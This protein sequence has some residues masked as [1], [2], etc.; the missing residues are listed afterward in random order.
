MRD[1]PL[2]IIWSAHR[3]GRSSE[4]KGGSKRSGCAIWGGEQEQIPEFTPG[5][6][7]QEDTV[8]SRVSIL[9]FCPH[10][11]QSLFPQPQFSLFLLPLAP[12]H[13]LNCVSLKIHR[14]SPDPSTS[15]CDCV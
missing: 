8:G 12:C 1:S 9:P 13:G 5:C 10:I 2:P 14:L 15:E 6:W 11:Q 4:P 7:G 3:G